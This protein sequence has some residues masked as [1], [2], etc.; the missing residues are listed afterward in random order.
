[1]A[2]KS[3]KILIVDDEEGIRELLAE[4]LR[5]RGYDVWTASDGQQGLDVAAPYK[6]DLILLDVMMPVMDGWQMLNCLRRNENTKHIPVAMLTGRGED[7]S[8]AIAKENQAS[9]YFVK[10]VNLDELISFIRRYLGG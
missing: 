2:A 1:M 5:L 7:Y 6:P 4:S 8:M 3:K 9:E 10:P